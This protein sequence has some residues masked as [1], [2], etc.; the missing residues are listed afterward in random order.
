MTFGWL[1]TGPQLRRRIEGGAPKENGRYRAN[2][3]YR[4]C[5]ANGH[6]LPEYA[7]THIRICAYYS[8]MSV[9]LVEPLAVALGAM[10]NCVSIERITDHKTLRP[11]V[12]AMFER[13]SSRAEQPDGLRTWIS[14][15]W[16]SVTLNN[17]PE[18]ITIGQFIYK[19]KMNT[20][21]FKDQKNVGHEWVRQPPLHVAQV[22]LETHVLIDEIVRL[23]TIT[24][25]DMEDGR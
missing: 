18:T 15:E 11:Q 9:S 12:V 4:Y 5:D 8:N 21:K 13:V 1:T 6:R 23:R 2:A 7:A 24:Q 19:L 20:P 22:G 16:R 17:L 10:S 25:T 14:N 3:S